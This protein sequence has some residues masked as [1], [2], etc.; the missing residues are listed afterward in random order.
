MHYVGS[1]GSKASSGGQRR[2][3]SACAEAQADLILRCAHMQTYRKCCVPAHL[4]LAEVVRHRVP[5]KIIAHEFLNLK[6]FIYISQKIRFE[7]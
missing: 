1:Q 2:L 7:C 3:C 4:Y 6:Y 5:F